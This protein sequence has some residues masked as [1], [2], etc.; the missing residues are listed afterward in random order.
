MNDDTTHAQDEIDDQPHQPETLFDQE[1]ISTEHVRREQDQSHFDIRQKLSGFA[2]IGITNESGE[3]LLASS[4][5]GEWWR[6]PHAR[7]ENGEDYATAATHAV[8]A[9]LGVE[10]D[11]VI[12][13]RRFVALLDGSPAADRA[14]NTENPDD[15]AILDGF[16]RST[17]YCSMPASTPLWRIKRSTST[18]SPTP[19]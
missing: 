4:S 10:V 14:A 8:E 15:L 18:G 3:V 12:H 6:L 11:S 17:T 19:P 16:A 9:R 5:D 13:V 1:S 7:V 2:I